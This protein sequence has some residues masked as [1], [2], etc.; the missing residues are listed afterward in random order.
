MIFTFDN[1]ITVFNELRISRSDS[2]YVKGTHWNDYLTHLKRCHVR[3]S[4]VVQQVM[5]LL[6]VLW[7]RGFDSPSSTVG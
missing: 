7:L 5:D 1:S 4:A 6:L 3:V 2:L